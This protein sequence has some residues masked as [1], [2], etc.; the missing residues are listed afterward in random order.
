MRRCP[1]ASRPGLNDSNNASPA[2]LLKRGAKYFPAREDFLWVATHGKEGKRPEVGSIAF[3]Y[4]GHYVMR[5]GWEPDARYLLLDAGPF[6]S[7]HQHEDKL[8]LI[9]YAYGRQL[10]LDAGNYMYDHS[11]WRR[12]VLSTRG[13]NTI[14]VDGQDQ[15]RRRL[16]D[17]YVLPQPFQPLDNTWIT[18]D[19]LDYA[20]GRYQNGYGPKGEL[21]VTHTRAVLFVKP[22]YWVVVDTLEPEDQESHEYESLFHFGADAAEVAEDQKFVVTRN[23][24]GP[25]IV[26]WPLGAQEISVVKGREEEPVQGWAQDPDWRAVPTAIIGANGVGKMRMAYVLYPLAEGKTSPIESVE[27]LPVSVGDKT[28]DD[29]IGLR[30][31]FRD[32]HVHTILCAEQP[33]THRRAGTLGTDAVAEWSDTLEKAAK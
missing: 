10:L 22:D 20:V 25:N 15:N 19:R 3:P 23:A 28:V 13:H 12:Y 16:R 9:A 26:L 21:R 4:S 11:R 14:R 2:E 33:G 30:I 31:R 17:T 29:A 8:H 7:G 32:G 18:K 5:S 27:Q 6:G 24:K 1:T